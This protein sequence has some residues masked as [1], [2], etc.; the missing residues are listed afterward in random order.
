MYYSSLNPGPITLKETNNFETIS[1]FIENPQSF[2]ESKAEG[3]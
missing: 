2:S 3:S 1:Q